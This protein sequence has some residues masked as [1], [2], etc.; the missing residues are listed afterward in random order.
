MPLIDVIRVFIIAL[1]I[2]V[3]FILMVL[4]CRVVAMPG[5]DSMVSLVGRGSIV[6]LRLRQYSVPGGGTAWCP[7]NRPLNKPRT[8]STSLIDL[9]TLCGLPWP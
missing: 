4:T 9:K 3:L 6:S 7:S 2:I 5:R 1:S 8:K